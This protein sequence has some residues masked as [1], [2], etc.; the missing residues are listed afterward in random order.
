MISPGMDWPMEKQDSH[1]I[2]SKK[3]QTGLFTGRNVEVEFH[4]P[5]RELTLKLVI[6]PVN[7]F[8]GHIIYIILLQV[9]KKSLAKK[10]SCFASF[11]QLVEG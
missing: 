4:A 3:R 8:M 5:D 2:M 6:I 11:T 7:H 10:T 9:E 1:L